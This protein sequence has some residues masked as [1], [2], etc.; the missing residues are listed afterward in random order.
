MYIVLGRSCRMSKDKGKPYYMVFLQSDTP[1]EGLEGS[2]CKP[3]W[4]TKS[5]YDKCEVGSVFD[6]LGFSEYSS[7]PKFQSITFIG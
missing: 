1:E 7:R 2:S 3:Y 6:T 5:V 4:C